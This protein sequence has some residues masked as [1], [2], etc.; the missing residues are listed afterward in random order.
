MLKFPGSTYLGISKFLL[1]SSSSGFPISFITMTADDFTK[2]L[3]KL[4]RI[5]RQV[6]WSF[7]SGQDDHTIADALSCS[8]NNISRHIN[9]ICTCMGVKDP[10]LPGTSCRP[11]LI[12]LCLAYIPDKV[13]PK[14][15]EKHQQHLTGADPSFPGASLSAESPFYVERVP[16]ELRAMKAVL[17]PGALVRIRSPHRTGKTSLL[18]RLLKTALDEGYAIAD[19]KLYQAEAAVI[20]DLRQFLKWFC[21]QVTETLGLPSVIEDY[22]SN[23]I[24]DATSCSRYLQF[25]VLKQLQQ[26]V[27]VAIDDAHRL[28]EYPQTAKAFF[29]LARG[30]FEDARRMGAWKEFRQVIIYDTEIYIDFDLRQSPFNVGTP[31]KLLPL[32]TKSVQNLAWRY[33]LKEIREDQVK[34]LMQLVEG[35]PYLTQM[36]LYHCYEGSDFEQILAQAATPMGIYK[37]HFEELTEKLSTHPNL[38]GAFREVLQAQG[39]RVS[40]ESTI[41]K[42]LEGLGL[43][44]VGQGAVVSC[45]LYQAFF[46]QYGF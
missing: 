20:A 18:N 21:L 30:W 31:I 8:P 15:K 45:R 1:F 2:R 25:H 7:L 26:P 32:K 5:Q 33:G 10:D 42:K 40:L 11:E 41:G 43:V 34:R 3:D 27:V 4:T 44:C 14:W 36:A 16:Q 22:W 28:F 37:D 46:D 38:I 13:A 35:H 19:I 17:R 6:L 39:A 9:N 12:D 24:A 29:S 23:Q